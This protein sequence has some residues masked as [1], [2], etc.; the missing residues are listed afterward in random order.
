MD[1]STK[2]FEGP[3][4]L[5]LALITDRKLAITEVSIA[6]VTEQ[7][8]QYLQDHRED[9]TLENLSDF[10][11][12]AARLILLKSKALLPLLVLEEDEEEQIV[13]LADQ[14]AE[15]QKFAEISGKIGAMWTEGRKMTTRTVPP[16]KRHVV[17]LPPENIAVSD[18]AQLFRSVL[19]DIPVVDQ[20]DQKRIQDVVA[21]EEKMMELSRSLK[22]RGT[23]AFSQ[24]VKKAKNKVDVIVSFLALLELVKQ[25]AITVDQQSAEGDISCTVTES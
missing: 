18:I 15:Y 7:Y 19:R 17:F 13:N 16:R 5:L 20:L 22:K 24:F 8:L 10:L 4:E 21:L 2:Q 23:V 3:L 12:M 9:I 1:F 6:E 25:N 14:L 11:D